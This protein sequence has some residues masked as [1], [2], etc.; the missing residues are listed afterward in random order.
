MTDFFAPLQPNTGMAALEKKSNASDGLYRPK[1]QEAKDK[2]IGYR[3]VLRFLPNMKQD[4]T[5]G[6]FLIERHMHYV[7]MANYVELNGYY[8]SMK[9]FNEKCE[10]TNTYWQLR[11]STSVL[12][13]EKAELIPYT[14]RYYAYVQIVED[15]QHP[16]LEGSIMIFPFGKKI[17]EKINQEKTGEISGEPCNVFDLAN[18]KD[19]ILIIKEVSG[20]PNYDASQFRQISSPI[21]LGGKVVSTEEQDGAKVIKPEFREAV[22]NYLLKRNNELEDY[23]PQRWTDEQAN[24]VKRI[25]GILTNNPVVAANNQIEAAKVATYEQQDSYIAPAKPASL[26]VDPDTFFNE[27]L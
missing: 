12:E 20:Y 11:N 19:F 16:E 3:A 10:L 17:K 18:G 4:K 7:K 22:S 24:N 13:N 5:R 9:N 21:R 8:D 25:I 15:E 27:P 1:S 2:K 14:T 26:V 23:A 6:E